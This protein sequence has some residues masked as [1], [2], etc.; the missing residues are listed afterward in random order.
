[1]E[2]EIGFIGFGEAAFNIARGL[3][4]AGVARIFA[5]DINAQT[6]RLGE[7]IRERAQASGTALID[8]SE[9]L[10]RSSDVLLSTVTANAAAE[11]AEQTAPFLESRHLYVDLN[12]VSPL[13]KRS[14]ERIIASSGARFV[15]G[16]IMSAV[17][18]RG[19]R[20]PILLGGANADDLVAL[21]APY[22]MCLEVISDQV[23]AASAVKMCRSIVIKGLEALLFECV[24]AARGYGADQRVL[25]SLADSLPGIDWSKLADYMVGRVVEHGERRAREMDEV[26]GTLRAIGIEPIMAEAAA[27]RREWGGRL[28]LLERLGK[29]PEGYREVVDAISAK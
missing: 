27:R 10:A 2:N 25:A 6:P 26:A 1:M 7:K 4:G 13:L 21:L 15:E 29:P 24:L 23:G 17:P 8:S 19:H 14:I 20:V 12:S 11:A 22:G 28:G 9:S 18:Q 3:R 16:A 5:Y